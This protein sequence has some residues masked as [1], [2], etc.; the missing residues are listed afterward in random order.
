MQNLIS[1]VV[2]FVIK[3]IL[4]VF[5]LVF[6]ASLLLAALIFVL[7][8]LV[9]AV[10]TGKKPEPLMVFGRFQ[11]FAPGDLWP[12]AGKAQNTSDVVDVEVREVQADGRPVKSDQLPR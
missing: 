9:K 3:L 4:T 11:K 6:A 1:W 5:G 10:I 8:S 12:G 2:R 7:L